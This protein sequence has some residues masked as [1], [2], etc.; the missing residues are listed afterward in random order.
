ML[1]PFPAAAVIRIVKA[2][3]DG[4]VQGGEMLVSRTRLSKL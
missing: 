4:V 3:R 2:F 1:R